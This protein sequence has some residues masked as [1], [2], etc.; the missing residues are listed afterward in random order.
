MVQLDSLLLFQRPTPALP[1]S[2]AAH[3]VPILATP[4]GY[5]AHITL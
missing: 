1:V 4:G 5:W 3:P 2:S